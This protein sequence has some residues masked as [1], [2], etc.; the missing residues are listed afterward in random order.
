[1][2]KNKTIYC[3]PSVYSVLNSRLFD[4]LHFNCKLKEE[5]HNFSPHELR[6]LNFTSRVINEPEESVKNLTTINI[7][8]SSSE[9]RFGLLLRVIESGRA[10]VGVHIPLLE[11]F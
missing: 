5:A 6:R 7:K 1:M 11:S 10:T 4:W 3:S 8:G 2:H 9:E